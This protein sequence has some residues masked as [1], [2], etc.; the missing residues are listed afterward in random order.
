MSDAEEQFYDEFEVMMATKYMF[1]VSI[2]NP[3]GLILGQ[4]VFLETGNGNT[5]KKEGL[6]LSASYVVQEETTYVWVANGFNRLEKR[7]I[8]LGEYDK[9][10][11]QYQIL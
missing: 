3:E 8:E 2:D 11:E 9:E 10:L 4:H 7:V 6:W 1:Y 5:E